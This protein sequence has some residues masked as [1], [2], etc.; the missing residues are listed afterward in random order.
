MALADLA[1]QVPRR[2]DAVGEN[3]RTGRA[4]ANAELVLFLALGESGRAALDQ[5]RGE[6][7]LSGVG[8][9]GDRALGEDGEEVR[10]TGVRDPHL[11]AIQRVGLPVGRRARPSCVH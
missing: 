2:D 3:Q 6:L 5:E 11:L 1:E 4:A 7:F 9:I 8:A 10:E